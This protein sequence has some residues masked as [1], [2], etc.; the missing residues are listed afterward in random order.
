MW[1]YDPHVLRPNRAECRREQSITVSSN[2]AI[3]LTHRVYLSLSHCRGSIQ[4]RT[5]FQGYCACRLPFVINTSADSRALV[6]VD[7]RSLAP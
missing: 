4:Y 5:E 3:Q 7:C 2:C 6:E 1:A